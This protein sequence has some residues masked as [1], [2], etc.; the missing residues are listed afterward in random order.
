M[1]FGLYGKT[2]I[3]ALIVAGGLGVAVGRMSR[4]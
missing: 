3:L 1:Y 4:R 2:A